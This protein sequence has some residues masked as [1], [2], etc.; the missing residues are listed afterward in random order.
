MISRDA[1]A[2]LV[3]M[4]FAR[5]LPRSSDPIAALCRGGVR[6]LIVLVFLLAAAGF[7]VGG[8]AQAHS[9]KP[10]AEASMVS[11]HHGTVHDA[12]LDG[13][14]CLFHCVPVVP[15]ALLSAPGPL[16]RSDRLPLVLQIASH[17][18]TPRVLAPPPR[19]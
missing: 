6:L 12:A 17:G 15:F 4:P 7:P 10:C 11:D 2:S 3:P 1:A 8:H 16:L 14:C 18:V 19:P 13:A 5:A 9:A